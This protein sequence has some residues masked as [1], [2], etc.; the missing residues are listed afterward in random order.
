MSSQSLERTISKVLS[1]TETE[2]IT[3]IDSTYKESLTNLENFKIEMMSEYERII[4]EGKKQAENIKRQI[5]G[6]SK[7]ESRNKELMLLETAVND[8]FEKT[9]SRLNSINDDP[10]YKKLLINMIDQSIP[11]FGSDSI[12]VE[13]NRRD[14]ELVKKCISEISKKS[15]NKLALSAEPINCA[16]GVRLKS[17]DGS[18]AIDNTIDSKIERLKPLI[19]K[20]IAKL[21]RGEV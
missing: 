16:G 17:S 1:E 2:L 19:R 8:S 6:S 10:L 21:L 7:L 11:L 15:G 5:I 9:K 18:L 14:T 13:C 20:N 4:E 12:I 3:K